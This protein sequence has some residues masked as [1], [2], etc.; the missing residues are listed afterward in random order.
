MANE[1]VGVCTFTIEGVPAVIVAV[2]VKPV[3]CGKPEHA[4]ADPPVLA[5]SD[6]AAICRFPLQ[7][8]YIEQHTFDSAENG[9]VQVNL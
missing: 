1:V 6:S 9:K 2:Q 8:V 4:D 3:V 7:V 5:S